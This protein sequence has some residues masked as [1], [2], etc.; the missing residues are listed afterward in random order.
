MAEFGAHIDLASF[1]THL[2]TTDVA[3]SLLTSMCPEYSTIAELSDAALGSEIV[4][5]SKAPDQLYQAAGKQLFHE[6]L[7]YWQLIGYPL[8]QWRFV[9]SLERLRKRLSLRGGKTYVVAGLSLGQS[10][11]TDAQLA[12]INAWVAIFDGIISPDP[13][14]AES[15]RLDITPGFCALESGLIFPIP[16][17]S[18]V[19]ANILI[20]STS[21]SEVRVPLD[22]IHMFESAVSVTEVI[23]GNR[24]LPSD[25][26]ILN[27]NNLHYWGCWIYWREMLA[28]QGIATKQSMFAFLAAIDLAMMG[29]IGWLVDTDKEE[30]EDPRTSIDK[31]QSELLPGFRFIRIC[32]ICS[33]DLQGVLSKAPF[34]RITGE[35]DSDSQALYELQGVMAAACKMW[36]PIDVAGRDLVRHTVRLGKFL[37]MP[38]GP[39]T[40]TPGQRA[41]CELSKDP[42]PD[43]REAWPVCEVIWK[44]IDER[45]R[46]Y[47]MEFVGH[48]LWSAMK[49]FCESR[50]RQPAAHVIP[51]IYRNR[52]QNRFPMPFVNFGGHFFTDWAL[53]D[54]DVFSSMHVPGPRITVDIMELLPLLADFS[55]QSGPS[56]GFIRGG[57]ANCQYAVGGLGCPVLGLSP[58]EKSKRDERGI[59]DYCYRVMSFRKAGLIGTG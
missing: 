8:F 40:R 4:A 35:A 44:E 5:F 10:T 23:V 31:L 16:T 2:V 27:A 39:E 59:G 45:R 47:T 55:E 37:F 11:M 38:D 29:D 3:S 21:G 50:C 25:D 51:G 36:L 33:A 1:I 9:F 57:I 18:V 48:K 28:K 56:C 20:R 58:E 49:N 12:Q 15:G 34:N 26:E 43:W 19:H 53:T 17:Y 42:L 6:R 22:P 54:K 7:H 41:V 46:Q 52:L 32:K 24:A 30:D 13:R 14:L